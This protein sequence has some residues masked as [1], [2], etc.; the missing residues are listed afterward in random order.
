MS[1]PASMLDVAGLTVQ[2]PPGADRTQAVS[3]VSFRVARGE[4]MGLVGESGSG[5]SMIAQTLM[6]LLPPGVRPVAGRA[7][8]EGEDLLSATPIRLRQLRGTRIA[9][10]FQE[11]MTALNPVLTCGRQI[12]ELLAQHTTLSG[13]ERRQR[14]LQVL[15]EV[16]LPD[17]RRMYRAYPHELS[18]GQRQR[19]VIAMALV[20]KPALLIAD[21]PTTALDVTT[22]AGILSLLRE[23]QRASGTGVLFITHDLGV[24][25]EIADRVG[26]LRLGKLVETGPVREVLGGPRHAYTRALLAAVPSFV[27]RKGLVD[28]QAP[29]HLRTRGLGRTFAGRGWFNPTRPVSAVEAVDLEVRRGETLGVVGESGSGKSTLARMMARLLMPTSGTLELDG[30]DQTAH[31]GAGARN[32]RRRV[33]VVF[34][35]PYRSLNPRRRVGAA[36]AEGPLNFGATAKSAMERA[37][38]LMDLVQLPRAALDRYPDEFSG[39]QR[40]RLCIARALAVHPEV[41]IADEAVSALDVSVQAQILQL[42]DD[43]QRRLH[44]TMI[45]ITHDLRVAAQMCNRLVVMRR[46]AIVET[47]ST[48]DIFKSPK[49]EYTR[50]LLSAAPGRSVSFGPAA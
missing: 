14:V 27:P 47:G 10:V 1:E 2:L 29:V 16:R 24:V 13:Q 37:E 43:V 49:H 39:G 46:G 12:D 45:F 25:S 38:E 8:L 4:L 18:G 35:D 23:L 33:Q 31:R 48:A 15:E 26:V 9:M 41:L 36:I 21:E 44:L 32:F 19:I 50:A 3:D 42:L 22:Q 11:P 17:A 20:L 6:G 30:T 28:E 7:S 34:Q 5:K 40:Q